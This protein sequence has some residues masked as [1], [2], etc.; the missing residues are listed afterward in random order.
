MNLIIDAHLD[1]SWN[2]LSWNRDLT[3]ELSVMNERERALTDDDARGNATVSLPE[4]RRGNVGVAVITLLARAKRQVQATRRIDLDYSTQDVSH[5]IAQGQ[6]AYY[7]RLAARN[8]I[9]WIS[10]VESLDAHLAAWERSKGKGPIGAILSMEGCDPIVEPAEAERW[11]KQGLRAAGIA[12]YG[13]GRYA[14]GTGA[15]GPVTPDGI[16]LLKEFD[17]LGM[18]VDLTHTAEPGFDQVLDNFGGAVLAS[19]QNCRALVPGDRQFSD[20]QLKRL[21][22]RDAVIGVV[23]D[24]WMLRPGWVIGQSKR[25]L[26][27]LESAADHILHVCELAGNRRH[28]AIGSDLDGGFG[29]EQ[30]PTGL[31]TIADLQKFENI[32]SK[33]GFSDEDIRAFMHGNWLRLFRASLPKR[34]P[35]IA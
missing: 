6:L 28:V 27:S 24:A 18:I 31:D 23:L 8:E 33:R 17:R 7:H 5:A 12:H 29:S 16:K 19:H 21:I 34:S 30:S 11:W 35:I 26:V 1:L 13:Q 15:E 32:L 14:M 4:M 9:R 22:A 20:A 10:D 3:E 25:D 2:A